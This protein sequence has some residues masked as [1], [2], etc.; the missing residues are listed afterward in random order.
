MPSVRHSLYSSSTTVPLNTT[1]FPVSR[2]ASIQQPAAIQPDAIQAGVPSAPAH[3]LSEAV[4]NT[5]HIMR[6]G[7]SLSRYRTNQG[8]NTAATAQNSSSTTKPDPFA[9][10]HTVVQPVDCTYPA[11]PNGQGIEHHVDS[12]PRVP[13]PFIQNMAY[14]QSSLVS[15]QQSGQLTKSSA[16]AT[17]SVTSRELVKPPLGRFAP[18]NVQPDIQPILQDRALRRLS[19]TDAF[20][21]YRTEYITRTPMPEPPARKDD[22][23]SRR[24]SLQLGNGLY[25]RPAFSPELDS[26][27]DTKAHLPVNSRTSYLKGEGKQSTATAVSASGTADS[28]LANVVRKPRTAYIRQAGEGP[29]HVQYKPTE[30][31]APGKDDPPMPIQNP[32]RSSLYEGQY[33]N[34]SDGGKKNHPSQLRRSSQPSLAGREVSTTHNLRLD[35][36]VRPLHDSESSQTVPKKA[37]SRDPSN[38]SLTMAEAA[39]E[40]PKSVLAG[41]GKRLKQKTRFMNEQ[42]QTAA[43]S[44][45]TAYR[46]LGQQQRTSGDE[47]QPITLRGHGKPL[48]TSAGVKST[49]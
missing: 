5:S 12:A 9:A 23:V 39:K 16:P 40:G 14:R 25:R 7:A 27:P 44:K 13:Q 49:A 36:A 1:G 43:S 3:L 17:I 4:S 24:A 18:E 6:G 19:R 48:I 29:L 8:K 2:P 28:K 38:S 11:A 32:K 41:P 35:S 37:L 10:H 22:N 21:L 46:Q 34:G 30:Q 47:V 20:P 33:N 15:G 45:N 31:Y 26:H 42:P